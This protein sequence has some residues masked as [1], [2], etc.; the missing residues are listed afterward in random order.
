MNAGNIT[1][2]IMGMRTFYPEGTYGPS[3][4]SGRVFNSYPYGGIKNV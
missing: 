1:L 2:K 3:V 4:Y